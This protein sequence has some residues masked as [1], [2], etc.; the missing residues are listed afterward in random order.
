MGDG[1]AARLTGDCGNAMAKVSTSDYFGRKRE[2]LRRP[3]SVLPLYR[4]CQIGEQR[5]RAKAACATILKGTPA[6]AGD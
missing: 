3:F 5:Q 2:R 6:R 4:P 1:R